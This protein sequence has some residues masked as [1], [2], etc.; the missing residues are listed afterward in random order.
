MKKNILSF[1]TVLMLTLCSLFNIVSAEND[2]KSPIYADKLNDGTYSIEVTSSSSMF[3]IVNCQLTD[4]DGKMTAVLT[5]SGTGYEKLFMGTGDEAESASDDSCIYFVENSDGKYTYTVP[6]EALD[7]EIDCAAWSIKKQQWYDRTIVFESET[8][9]E[10][11]LKGGLNNNV[12]I[13]AAAA[14]AVI[15]VI[16]VIVIIRLKKKKTA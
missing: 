10:G 2:S 8:L 11:A 15:A 4:S 9:P 3:K 12:I 1:F 6:V 5:L 16:A 14:V 13:I 7:K